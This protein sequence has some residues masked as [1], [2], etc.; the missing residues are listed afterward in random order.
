MNNNKYYL[1]DG[2]TTLQVYTSLFAFGSALEEGHTYNITGVYQ[3]FNDTKEVLPRSANDIEEVISEE[4]S[5]SVDPIAVNISADGNEGI[6]TVTYNNIETDLG[7]EIYWYNAEG[8]LIDGFDWIMADFN[9]D[10]NI[11]YTISANDGEARTA[12]MKVFA[13]DSELN[14]VYSDL[15][16]F[17]QAEYTVDYATLPFAFD[18]GRADI[19]NTVGLTQEGLDS[20]YNTSPKLKFKSTGSWVLLHFN[21][22]PGKLTFDIKGNSFSEGTFTVQTSEDGETYTDLA[23]YTEL[24]NTQSETFNTLG[25]DVRY[26]K[27]VYTNKVNG[28]VALGNIELRA[29][30]DVPQQYDLT[31]SEFENL[32]IFTFVDDLNELAL[33]GAGTIQVNENANVSLS[34]SANEGYIIGSLVVDGENVTSQIDETGLYTF[35]MPSHNVTITA[36]AIENVPG[37]WVLTDIADLTENDVFVIVET[38]DGVSHAMANDGSSAPAAVEVTVVGNT[39]SSEP[40]ANLQWNIS[41]NATDGY[42][43]YPNGSDTTWLYGFNNNN[44]L[45]VGNSDANLFTIDAES[46]YLVHVETGRYIGVYLN[47][48]DWRCYTT[49]NSNIEGQTFAFYKKVTSTTQTTALEAGVNWFSSYVEITLDDLKAALVATGNTAITI[50]SQNQNTTYNPNNGRWIGQLRT[51]DLSQMYM[52]NVAVASELTLEGMPIDPS[53]HPATIAPG[54]NYIAYP[55]NTNM[56]VTNAFAGFGIPNDQVQSQLQN[57]YY[58]GTRWIGQLRNLEPGKGYLYNSVSTETRTFTFPLGN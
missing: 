45:R 29:A 7:T 39:L 44:G 2:T 54:V 30:T 41:G 35:V 46:G 24:S 10:M 15:I 42:I 56:T 51:L 53:M 20:D 34:V 25:A 36:T 33:E 1:T 31:V 48:P 4:P 8:T 26:I 11:E 5:I 9:D 18:G 14:E 17:N 52:I 49:I 38:K 55:F 12:Y 6:L 50:S 22:A 19:A 23:T 16:T 27:W 21:E 13:F 28:N 57:T 3:Q 32:E 37:N 58:N 40:A 43:F 47:N